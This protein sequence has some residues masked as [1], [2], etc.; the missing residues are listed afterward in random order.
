MNQRV[1]VDIEKSTD[2]CVG[3][4]SRNERV[5]YAGK[6]VTAL[7]DRES[8][9][10]VY[11]ILAAT[12]GVSFCQA[13]TAKDFPFYPVPMIEIFAT[14]GRGG[15]FASVGGPC[16]LYEEEDF[17]IVYIASDQ[18]S[19]LMAQGLRDFLS[20]CVFFP[21]WK[22]FLAGSPQSLDQLEQ[23]YLAAH[24]S[25]RSHQKIIADLFGLER[26]ES[27]LYSLGAAAA[28]VTL[29]SSRREAEKENRFFPLSEQEL[30][31]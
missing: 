1:L 17:P 24:P 22:A 31:H 30:K 8:H 26:R 9:Q 4:F 6:S 3:V 15:C 5:V 25:L 20:L 16:S 12:F 29:Y 19:T 2:G 27:L 10:T 13:Q 21:Y 23:D 14:D 7:T 11:R 28:P 18:K